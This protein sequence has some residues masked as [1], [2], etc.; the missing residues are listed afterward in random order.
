MIVKS[1]KI[2]V[3]L[4]ILSAG[5]WFLPATP[6]GEGAQRLQSGDKTRGYHC[7]FMGHSFFYPIAE[8]FGQ[9][10]VACGFPEHRQVL[11]KAG[12][13]KGTP[14]WLWRN[15]PRDEKVWTTL[16]SEDVD[17]L[18]FAHHHVSGCKLEDYCNWIDYARK[19]NP[20]IMVAIAIPWGPLYDSPPEA[21]SS[22]YR[23]R[24]EVPVRELVDTLRQKY[25]E[26]AIFAIPHGRGVADLYSK[27]KAGEIT[28]IEQL[29][30]PEGQDEVEAFFT[31]WGAHID[32]MPVVL[33]QL[34]WLATI[35]QMDVRQ[36]PWETGYQVDLKQMAHDIVSNDPYAKIVKEKQTQGNTG[37]SR[38]EPDTEGDGLRT[39]P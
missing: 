39:A 8:T 15:V 24:F 18:C 7:V 33:S 14:G 35:Y 31:D 27:Y 19:R 26:N 4:V 2:Q 1:I 25:P 13:T 21:F 5:A 36:C 32:R 38:S 23:N 20:E 16:A 37:G 12:A 28:E 34:I 17:L 10:A 6:R 29:L 3:A 9:V 11:R 22:F 30:Q